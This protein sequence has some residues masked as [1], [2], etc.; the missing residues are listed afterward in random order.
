[1]IL[2]LN[3]R[4][5][6]VAIISTT[7]LRT[8]YLQWVPVIRSFSRGFHRTNKYDAAEKKG[9]L[10]NQ[11]RVIIFLIHSLIASNAAELNSPKKQKNK[12]PKKVTHQ[13]KANHWK[14]KTAPSTNH[15]KTKPNHWIF[16]IGD[17][18]PIVLKHENWQHIYSSTIW[19]PKRFS[20]QP[21][22][23]SS[24]IPLSPLGDVITRNEHSHPQ[25]ESRSS[26]LTNFGLHALPT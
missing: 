13:A 17:Y 25:G 22:S 4:E 8:K 21:S 11:N 7:H 14:K 2:S 23:Y 24:S 12:K 3:S 10:P 15:E 18:C 9:T 1:M 26:R 5:R 6:S 20:S 19:M 16:N